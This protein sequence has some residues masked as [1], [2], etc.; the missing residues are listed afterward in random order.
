MLYD[1]FNISSALFILCFAL[2]QP[3]FF[4][5]AFI[6]SSSFD[7]LASSALSTCWCAR[8]F[9][10]A[11]GTNK[12]YRLEERVIRRTNALTRKVDLESTRRWL[13]HS[14][15]RHLTFSIS[16]FRILFLSTEENLFPSCELKG[17]DRRY[18]CWVSL[19]GLF[20]QKHRE[21]NSYGL[22][23]DISQA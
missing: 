21:K 23:L 17:N 16:S 12:E 11:S 3:V 15:A 2:Y 13:R 4:S 20:S 10:K 14:S 7:Y 8:G 5:W 19:P 6:L 18:S 1:K 9:R 22:R